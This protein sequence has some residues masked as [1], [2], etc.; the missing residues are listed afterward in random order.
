MKAVRNSGI[1]ALAVMMLLAASAFAA[2]K[3]SLQVNNNVTVNGKQLKAGDYS[4]MWDGDGPDVQLSIMQGKKVVA[5]TP[6]KVVNLNAPANNNEAVVIRGTDGAS[7]LQEIRLRGK[8]F[9][10]AIAP[11]SASGGGSSNGASANTN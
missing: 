1:A 11:A 6:A 5:Q 9:S 2:N 10:L 7:S 3:G 8:K 4:L